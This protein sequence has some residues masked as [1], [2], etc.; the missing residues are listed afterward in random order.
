MKKVL[1]TGVA[2]LALAIAIAAPVQAKQVTMP[3]EFIG[4]WCYETGNDDPNVRVDERFSYVLPSWVPE[5]ETCNKDKILSVE[6]YGFYFHDENTQFIPISVV[7]KEDCAPSGCGTSAKIT[8]QEW[9]NNPKSK[10]RIF[11]ISRYKG[12]LAVEEAKGPTAAMQIRCFWNMTAKGC[13][14]YDLD[15]CTDSGV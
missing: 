1:A 13:P 2:L 7:S 12:H 6:G 11:L 9:P 5:G 4:E 10:N 3:A 8:A 14:K 15:D